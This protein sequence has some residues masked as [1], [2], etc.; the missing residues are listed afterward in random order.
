MQIVLEILSVEKRSGISKK[1]GVP[2]P[3][4][5]TVAQCVVH[6]E[7]IQVGELLLP[8]DMPEPKP[9]KYTGDFEIVVD[10]D[11]RIGGRLVK[12]NPVAVAGAKAA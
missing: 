3:Y 2:T 8:K 10:F 7:K 12:L 6:G 9:G 5:M 4:E 1:T 11:K